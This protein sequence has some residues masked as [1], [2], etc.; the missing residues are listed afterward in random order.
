MLDTLPNNL[1][2][3]LLSR[4]HPAPS[5]ETIPHSHAKGTPR[6]WFLSVEWRPMLR[7]GIAVAGRARLS[8]L[9]SVADA[10]VRNWRRIAFNPITERM[11]VRLPRLVVIAI[12]ILTIGQMPRGVAAALPIFD[13]HLHYNGEAAAVYPVSQVL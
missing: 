8:A 6:S 4:A 10:A 5:Q 9:A 3:T 7:G 12:V 13:A 2:Q 11:P 1:K